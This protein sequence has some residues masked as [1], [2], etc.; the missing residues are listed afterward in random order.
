MKRA[1]EELN[2]PDNQN[3]DEFVN[4]DQNIPTEDNADPKNLV[5]EQTESNKENETDE[6]IEEI[7][8]E[9]NKVKIYD[10][11][12]IY[13]KLKTFSKDDYVSFKQVKNL[14]CHF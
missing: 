5:I 14:E 2:I 6:E 11:A 7:Q 3:L 4:I 9:A 12:L 13:I 10:E 1:A 8:E